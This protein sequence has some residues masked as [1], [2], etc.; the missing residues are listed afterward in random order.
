[1]VISLE[2]AQKKSVSKRHFYNGMGRINWYLPDFKNKLCT[3]EFL[4]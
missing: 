4:L 2:E 3:W 1:M